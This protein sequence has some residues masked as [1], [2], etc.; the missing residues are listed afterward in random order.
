VA[1]FGQAGINWESVESMAMG[2]IRNPKQERFAEEIADGVDPA[3]AYVNA[4][5]ERS[6]ANHW[7]LMREPKV[8]ARIEALKHKREQNAR[9]AMMSID[10]VLEALRQCGVTTV[11]DFFERDCA[12]RLRVRNLQ[13]VSVVA[14][15]ALLRYLRDGLAITSDFERPVKVGDA[16]IGG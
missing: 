12:G 8:A 13:S 3:T 6:R 7:R 15:T 14:A 4:G 2:A 9:A 5:F 1:A 10:D 11:G 16:V